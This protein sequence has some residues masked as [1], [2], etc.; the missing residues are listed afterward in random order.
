MS[1]IGNDHGKDNDHDKD[2]SDS[3]YDKKDEIA[4]SKEKKNSIINH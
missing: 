2:D 1:M 4:G 3:K